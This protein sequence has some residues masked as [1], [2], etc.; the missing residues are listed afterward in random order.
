MPKRTVAIQTNPVVVDSIMYAP[1]VGH[2]IVAVD[3]T[4][5]EEKWRFN[6]GSPPTHR[7]IF[8]WENPPKGIGDRI[9][10]TS[11]LKLMAL[12]AS[13]GELDPSFGEGGIIPIADSCKVPV[14]VFENT[15]VIAGAKRHVYGYDATTGEQLW[16]F[17]TVPKAGEFGWETWQDPEPGASAN[18]WSGITLDE[19]RGIVYVPTASPKPNFMGNLNYG[20]NPLCQLYYRHRRSNRRA[21]M[22]PSRSCDM[23]F[24]T[25][26]F[27]VL[28]Y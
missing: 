11:E 22:A 1:T 25:K 12:Q 10:F 15:V 13:S 14:V 2:N 23:T 28:R 26:M 8:Y 7:G 9:V 6:P 3:G 19:E 21:P 4:S 17:H 20:R 27:R 5:G 18:S 16:V 24:G